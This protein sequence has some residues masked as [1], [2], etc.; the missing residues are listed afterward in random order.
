MLAYGHSPYLRECVESVT[1]Q[2]VGSR[3]SVATSTPSEFIASV[4]ESF[5]LPIHTNTHRNGIAADWNFALSSAT[6]QFV[7]LA[8]QD[9]IYYPEFAERSCRR[10]LEAPDAALCFTDYEEIDKPRPGKVLLV[11]RVLRRAAIGQRLSVDSY[12]RRRLLLSFGC[13][14]P[15]TTV[16]LNRE[17]LGPFL[18]SDQY[19]IN[20]DWDAWWRL[21]VDNKSFLHCH[22]ILV[23]HRIHEA[24]ET[25]RAKLDGRRKAED[26][27]MFA[28]IWPYPMGRVL[29]LLYRLGY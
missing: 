4:A 2:T 8:H 24:A 9:D 6:E 28:T 18:F 7:T 3:V 23:G 13:A 17:A 27:R 20:M 22:D 25:S 11:K 21:H 5:N 12:W 1:S 26:A 14:I 10:F 19:S 16:T 29:S 15:C